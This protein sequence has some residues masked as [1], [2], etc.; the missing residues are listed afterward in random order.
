MANDRIIGV[1]EG[2]RRV[3]EHHHR[4]TVHDICSLRRRNQFIAHFKTIKVRITP[5]VE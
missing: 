3:G 4:A 1:N 2:G 5:H